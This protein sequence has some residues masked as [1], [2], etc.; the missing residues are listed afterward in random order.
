MVNEQRKIVIIGG[1]IT[2]LVA[3]FYTKKRYEKLCIPVEITIV[4]KGKALGGKIQTIRRAGFII[5]RGPDSFLARKPSI[6]ALTKELGIENELI[7]TDPSNKAN[8]ILHKGK[9]HPMPL[10]LVLGIPTEIKPFI[11]TGLIS[12]LGKVRAAFDLLLPKKKDGGDEALGSF[13]KRRLGKEVLENI[14]EPLLAGIYAGD[15]ETLSLDSTFPQFKQL[16]QKHRSLMVGMLASKKKQRTVP[17]LP[18][19]A[20][21]SLFLS[22]KN[23]L[24]T[25]IESLVQALHT[26]QII[27]GQGVTKIKKRE[28][29]FQLTLENDEELYAD[30]VI[31]AA[32]APQAA[33][34]F[35][36][37][38]IMNTLGQT[39]YVS[40]ANVAL[41]YNQEDISFPMTGSGFVVPR[42]E[43]RTIT[44]CTWS[45]SKWAHVAPQGKVL[46]RTYIGRSGAEEWVHLSDEEILTNV[47]KDLQEIM[48][49][50]SKPSFSIISRHHHSMP[51]YEVGHLEKLRK[52][53]EQLKNQM[54]GIFLCGAGYEGVGIPDCIRQ[55]KTAAEEM[56]EFIEKQK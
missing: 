41:A 25:V 31:V 56:V 2:G 51:Q 38:A 4:E 18:E 20:Q 45:S 42:K 7:A 15:T 54:P 47:Q 33:K 22:Y 44:A 10:G 13:I 24:A 14:T 39:N 26:E 35:P 16:E 19:I 34:L 55:G 12:P 28:G 8:Y 3:A 9:L 11:K 40:V 1:G 32:Q 21:K 50:T 17:N 29:C 30:G 52:T 53:R 46:L 43:G 37:Q 23:G 5:E 27:T 49:V 6:L 36:E 48:G